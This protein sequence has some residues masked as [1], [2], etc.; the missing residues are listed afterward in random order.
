MTMKTICKHGKVIP[1]GTKCKC[2]THTTP[3][4]KRESSDVDKLR[5]TDRWKRKTRPRI[6]NR[7][8]GLCQRCLIKYNIINSDE[9]QIHHI[10]SA[11][12]HKELFFEDSNLITLCK[13]CNL[14]LG[15]KDELDFDCKTFEE[16]EYKL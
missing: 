10:K 8:N 11:V 7:D 2:I 14:Q 13:T 4:I 16:Y 6:I 5:N 1:M 15:T 9:L 3:R 12:N